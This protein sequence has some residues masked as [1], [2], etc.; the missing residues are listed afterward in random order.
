MSA[1]RNIV[2]VGAGQTAAWAAKTM[3]VEGFDGRISLVGLEEHP[4]YERPPLSKQVLAGEAA[5]ESAY[6]FPLQVYRDMA[7]D[8][9]LG[10][11]AMMLDVPGSKVVLSDGKALGYDRLL[12]ATGGTP[13]QLRLPGAEMAGV[14]YLRSIADSAA[15]NAAITA[16]AHIL[17]VGGGWI[18]LEVA[19]TARKLGA[20]VTL[21]EHAPLLAGRCVPPETSQFLLSLHRDHDVDVIPSARLGAFEGDGRVERVRF[22][23]GTTREVSA[24]VVGI[25]LEPSVDLAEQSGINIAN[26]I[27]VDEMWR[28]SAPNIYA[29]GDVASFISTTGR[30][31]R[32]ESWDNAQKQGAAAAKGM[33]GKTTL[34]DS[35]PW[36]WSD[37]YDQNIQMLGNTV[38]FDESVRVD[39]PPAKARMDVY[40]SRGAVVGAIA[41]NAGRE[42]RALKRLLQNGSPVGLSALT[43]AKLPIRDRADA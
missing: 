7:V 27:L 43:Q 13:R 10:V 4:P 22:Q 9:R 35:H 25:G 6:I 12:L 3:R 41:I 31:M 34:P 42:L 26:G 20:R 36:F 18:G 8:M 33:F 14:H 23:D 17:V 21:V 1:V 19:A 24:V 28:T 30:R 11:R 40:L 29:A 16:S 5:P 38:D 2:I 32:L 39:L 37:Q 15:I